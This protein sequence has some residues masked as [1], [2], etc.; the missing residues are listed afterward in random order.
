[1]A[2]MEVVTNQSLLEQGYQ[3]IVEEIGN[4]GYNI[5]DDN[6][7]DTSARC[8]KA[9]LEVVWSKE[10]INIVCKEILS[11]SFAQDFDEMIVETNIPV[12]SLCPHHLLPVEMKVSIGYVA[13]GRV[14]GL[15]KLARLAKVLGKQPILQEEYTR[16][17]G[18]TI[19]YELD[20]QGVGVFVVGKHG[21]MRF[22]GVNVPESDTITSYMVGNF[23]EN[24]ATKQEFLHFCRDSRNG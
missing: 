23:R 13:R 22:R 2:N 6:F 10:S 15:S 21:C 12:V 4:L 9:V 1:M 11:K 8:A 20:P 14:L 17:V 5:R 18:Q 16:Q 19:K 3:Q 24:A 7:R